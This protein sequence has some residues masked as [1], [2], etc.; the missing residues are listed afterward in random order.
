MIA[1]IYSYFFFLA[2]LPGQ[3]VKDSIL[4]SFT[5]LKK[6]THEGAGER[7]SLAAGQKRHVSEELTGK[8][9]KGPPCW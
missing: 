9:R 5:V 3:G 4:L 2:G 1:L 6:C 8:G 7:D